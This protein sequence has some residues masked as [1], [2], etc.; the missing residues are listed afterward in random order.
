MNVLMRDDS[1]ERF[2]PTPYHKEQ[3]DGRRGAKEDKR[4]RADWLRF[5]RRAR[6]WKLQVSRKRERDGL[7]NDSD[8]QE[9]EKVPS[10]EIRVDTMV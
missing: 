10:C 3:A 6:L 8:L 2:R 7:C 4:E 5:G 9:E 1:P